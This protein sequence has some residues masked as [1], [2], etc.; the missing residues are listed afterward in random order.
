MQ[1]LLLPLAPF[2]L[3]TSSELELVAPPP[4]ATSETRAPSLSTSNNTE[5]ATRRQDG[6]QQEERR[7]GCK[8]YFQTGSVNKGVGGLTA[9]ACSFGKLQNSN[10]RA[11][12][13]RGL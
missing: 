2:P 7:K 10:C 8:S 9:Q 5:C 11:R 12:P 4:N 6:A 3:E 1:T 13:K